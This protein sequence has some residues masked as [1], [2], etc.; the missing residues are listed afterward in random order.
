MAFRREIDHMSFHFQNWF[1]GMISASA[2]E[3]V[4][5]LWMIGR[6][7]LSKGAAVRG[8]VFRR[9]GSQR[10]ERHTL[11]WGSRVKFIEDTCH[12]TCFL[13]QV[14][15]FV[16]DFLYFGKREHRKGM[17]HTHLVAQSPSPANH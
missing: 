10:E 9:R 3:F 16:S 12:H 14:V 15:D 8:S 4:W 5:Q 2:D 7:L 6:T 17:G 1:G 13:V 11:I